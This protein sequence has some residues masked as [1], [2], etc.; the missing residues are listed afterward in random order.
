LHVFRSCL[1]SSHRTAQLL[2]ISRARRGPM[3][4][5]IVAAPEFGWSPR[6]GGPLASPSF[7]PQSPPHLSRPATGRTEV[8][9]P[10]RVPRDLSVRAVPLVRQSIGE[11]DRCDDPM[12]CQVDVS[13]CSPCIANHPGAWWRQRGGLRLGQ[14]HVQPELPQWGR[15]VFTDTCRPDPAPGPHPHPGGW[16]PGWGHWGT[17]SCAARAVAASDRRASPGRLC[18]GPAASSRYRGPWRYNWHRGWG[19]QPPRPPGLLR[20]RSTGRGGGA[21]CARTSAHRASAA[22]EHR[23][24]RGGHHRL[25]E[26]PC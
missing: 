15:G 24:V 23:F 11:G 10:G 21:V 4:V 12:A 16:C 17:T 20:Y 1:P 25:C 13:M 3:V 2:S 6:D 5:S 14:R 9:T 8:V 19:R 22:A 26:S 7:R 18:P